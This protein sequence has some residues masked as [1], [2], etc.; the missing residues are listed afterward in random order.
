MQSETR[1]I[2][3]FTVSGK[4][5][6]LQLPSPVTQGQAVTVTYFDPTERVNDD[7]AIQD[8]LGNDAATVTSDVNN[9]SATLDETAP[10]FQ[11]AVL[12]SNGSTIVM[13]YNE[14]LDS[15]NKAPTSAFT[16]EADSSAVTLTGVYVTGRNVEVDLQS[17]VT[18]DQTVTVAYTDP[19][20]QDDE[21]AIQDDPAGNDAASLTAQTVHGES[22]A[23]DG[24]PPGSS[25]RSYQLRATT[26][27]LT[28]DE[29][30]DGTKGPRTSDFS[31]TV[32]GESR[33][34]S[35]VTV[36]GQTVTLTLPTIV[37]SDE[38]VSVTYT[39]P[40]ADFDDP[41]AIQDLDG[42]DAASLSRKVTN[43]STVEDGAG[44]DFVNAATSDDG[45]R[46]ILTFSEV[47]YSDDASVPF[48]T[49]FTIKV[50]EQEVQLAS[51]TPVLIRGRTVELALDTEVTAGQTVTVTYT[52]PTA[53]D[54]TGNRPFRTRL[55]TMRRASKTRRSQTTPR[56]RPHVP[57]RRRAPRPPAPRPDH[58]RRALRRELH[59][60]RLF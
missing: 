9:Q 23:P 30:L 20:D 31:H 44:P 1:D 6:T 60:D 56:R 16:V 43:G 35:D 29:D 39:D 22:T 25:A 45:K 10:V 21:N 2:D 50:D 17:A 38:V 37:T 7:N 48:N 58:R 14:V 41:N 28:F 59:R 12:S 4:T 24:D 55:V 19:S 53:V 34:V 42:N 15:L 5:V 13:V 36:S 33:D 27:V 26:I 57:Q 18:E 54:G 52:A 47:L 40:R 46:I 49:D 8:R 32:H 51:S 3:S 11:Y